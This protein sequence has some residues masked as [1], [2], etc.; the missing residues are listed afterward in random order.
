MNWA[1]VIGID[2]YWKKEACLKGAV[3]DA[4]TMR[5]WLLDK[6]GGNVPEENIALIL[7]P[8]AGNEPKDVQAAEATNAGILNAIHDLL[9]KSKYE[10]ERLYFFYAGHGLTARINQRDENALVCSDFTEVLTTNSIALR[11]LWEFFETVQFQDQFFFVDA[12]R[13]I[14]WENVEFEIGR[15]SLP[16]KRDPGLPPTQQ[17]IL[18]A[19]SPGLPAQ[20]MQEAGNERGAFTE[21]LM[22]GLGGAGKAKV[23]SPE[24]Q[25]YQVRWERLV[26]HVKDELEARR[27][28]VPAG[29]GQDVFQIP[30]D[31]G[32]HGVAG[33]ERTPTLASF[34]DG[35]FDKEK[36]VILLQPDDVVPVAEVIVL[37]ESAVT[38]DTQKGRTGT[39]VE[40]SLPP[41]T[42]ALHATAPQYDRAVARPPIELYGACKVPLDLTPTAQGEAPP[43][44]NGAPTRSL[45]AEP[46]A[47]AAD[48]VVLGHDPLVPVEVADATGRVL[49]VASG[50]VSLPG[51]AP[52]FYR[53]RLLSPGDKVVEETIEHVPGPAR[54]V[55]LEAPAPSPIVNKLVK[56]IDAPLAGGR[57]TFEV[58]EAAGPVASPHLSTI[59]T[60]AGGAAVQGDPGSGEKLRKLGLGAFKDVL[61]EDPGVYVV[62]GADS[63][64]S[65]VARSYLTNAK[66]R[67]WKI[68]EPV[69]RDY[70][71]LRELEKF[72][73][74]GE[75]AQP[76]PPGAYW[77]SLEP[78]G[79]NAIAFAL[80]TLPGRVTMLT[81]ELREGQMQIFQYLPSPTADASSDPDA[82]RRVELLERIMLDGRLD[83][84]GDLAQEVFDRE[85]DDPLAG[86]LA[87]Y[88]FLRVGRVAELG[89]AVERLTSA[90]GELSD[91]HVIRGEYEA[92][93]GR[94]EAAKAA[95]TKAIEV[96]VPIFGE[97]LTRLLEGLRAY[98]IEHPVKTLVK[99]VF[100]EH[101]SGSMWSVCRP[102]KVVPGELLVP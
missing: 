95:F 80:A 53:L 88:L 33:R 17:F 75:F 76:A 59:L 49:Q 55:E 67:V 4:L 37:D 23:W 51:L 19:T 21:V 81:I 22:K 64:D 52:G 102:S 71:T 35:A 3:Q 29:V 90:Y 99:F 92:A 28:A 58:S 62:L 47:V 79:E 38:V 77:L 25:N 39:P 61:G 97:G 72:P 5:T 94:P 10:G 41:K 48:L 89:E 30:Q 69:P 16:R 24:K 20:E 65:E 86:A 31:A 101:M 7:S 87:C 32:A 44:G 54:T 100:D 42:Y 18:Y 74:I 57:N 8:V 1:I 36:L 78:E 27:L 34:P 13:N 43:A 85:I 9:Q 96:G 91:L 73:G 15:W 11:S 66:L 60:L 82:L 14:P 46:A 84:G 2:R 93:S 68:G 83:S 50:R 63:P 40:F 56:T 12:C 6:A 45:D 70:L 98:E 26:D